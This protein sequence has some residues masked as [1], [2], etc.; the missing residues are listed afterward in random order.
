MRAV[1]G[2]LQAGSPG[3][4]MRRSLLLLSALL[5]AL[6]VAGTS[7]AASTFF[8]SGRGW[9]HGI[10]LSQY[11]A[12]GFAREGWTHD[13]ILAHYYTGT[14]LG[15]APVSQVRVL[16]AE[17]RGSLS[18]GSAADFTATDAAG[19]TFTVPAGTYRLGP[20]LRLRAG[21]EERTLASPV[22]FEPGAEPLALDRRYRGA[23]VVSVSG[24]KLNAVNAVGLEAYLYGVVPREMPASWDAEALKA[25]AVAA[26][27]YA[28]VSMRSGGSFDLYSDTRSQVYGGLDAEDARANAAI[29]ATAG[30][31]VLYGGAVAHTFF[32]STSG[33][34]TAAIAD[35]WPGSQ[36]LPYLVSVED[37][38]DDLSPYHRWGP[39]R[40][41]AAQL[42]SGLSARVPGGLRDALIVRNASDRVATLTLVGRRGLVNVPG[43]QVRGGLGL[44]SSWIDIDV[45]ALEPATPTAEFG[46]KLALGGVVRGFAD[47]RVEQRETGGAWAEVGPVVAGQGGSFSLE[48]TPRATTTYRLTAGA[49]IGPSVRVRVA[50]RVNFYASQEAGSLRGRVRPKTEGAQVTIQRLEGARWVAVATAATDAKGDFAASFA[51]VAGTYRAVARIGGA[52]A[53]GTSPTLDVVMG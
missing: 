25:Q 15:P 2:Y 9:G 26:R 21:G 29:D 7:S 46:R 6:A 49:T 31:V 18:I 33:G 10:G 47:V 23:I 37:P 45:L 4:S 13:R 12:Y 20:K 48:V 50:P 41:S 27:S 19:Q 51:V 53:P 5:A 39:V 42:T 38:H 36:P 34:R 22:R 43:E 14:T 40:F 16:L 17:G 30:Q 11:G 3:R 52:F 8:V 35:V 1:F 44:R 28:L 32:F 24:R